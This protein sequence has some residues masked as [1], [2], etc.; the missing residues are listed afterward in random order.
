MKYTKALSLIAASSLLM[1]GLSGCGEDTEIVENN[2]TVYVDRNVTVEVEKINLGHQQIR[3]DGS[4]DYIDY[5]GEIRHAPASVGASEY[6]TGTGYGNTLFDSA[7]NK[8]Q[9][10]HNE[11]YDTWEGSM[12]GRSWTDP[13]FQSKFQ[14]FLRTHLAKIGTTSDV[15]YEQASVGVGTKNMF[16][17]A[18]QTC[19]KCHA[20]GAYYAG[21]VKVTVSEIADATDLNT[22]QLADLK[23]THEKS[24]PAGELAVIAANKIANKIYKATFEIGHKANKEGINCAFCHSI[25]TP[26]LMGLGNDNDTYTLKGDIRVGPHGT[27]K[28]AAGSD[29]I[30]NVDA[31][32]A[33]MNKFFRL[34]GPEKY[35]N[36]ANTPKDANDF[37][38]NKSKDGRYTMHS[39]DLNGTNGKTHYT[40][41]PFYGP[42]GVTGKNNENVTDDTNRSAH[43]NPH[44]NTDDG[45]NHFAENGKAL[46]LSCHQRSAGAATPAGE[47]GA[48]KFMELCSTWNAVTTGT[49]SN[50]NNDM[51]SPKCQKCHMERIEGTV[52]HKWAE[53]NQLFSDK[54]VLTPHFYPEDDDNYGDDNP[55][56]AKWLNSHAFLGASK[57]GGDKAAAVAKIKSGFDADVT[58]S[59]DGSTLTV[60]TTITN[61]T[62]HMF[63]GAH[64]MRRTLSRLIVTDTDGKMLPV[65][66]A[67]GNS[68]FGQITNTIATLTGKTISATG[69]AT[70]TLDDASNAD[71]DFPGK[72]ADLNGSMQTS[73][74]FDASFVT[75]TGTDGTIGS[76]SI[77]DGVTTGT[78]FNAAIVDSN[79]T[80]NFTRIYGHETGKKY[81]GVFVVRP[82][83]DSNMVA[84]D[85]R[86]SP[87]ETETYTTTYDITGKSGVSTTYKVYYMQKGANGKF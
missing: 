18:S 19:I 29:L 76:Q 48:G 69:D 26:R 44:F 21:D 55:V 12:H 71:L 49:D 56:S 33:D 22:T 51:T 37:D 54:N 20:P 62:G 13:I 59:S 24:N 15:V 79:D 36:P 47:A 75:I 73:Q 4:I 50:H 7:E 74:K 83:F 39:I 77:T 30:Y 68:T 81:D 52:L 57:T 40:G 60:T 1:V 10:C 86:L 11:L 67:T 41:G 17:G 63:P 85:T 61:K 64:P 80:T 78:V 14:D 87:N 45:F 38:V 6:H 25:E 16:S 53:P 31:T 42:Y 58:T 27:I 28:A 35:V 2:V 46:C 66:S 70:V 72:V 34:W 82:G 65:A 3:E 84:S 5:K 32:D 23:A 9:N 8:C 43:V